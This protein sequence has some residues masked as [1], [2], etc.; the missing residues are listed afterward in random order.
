[1]PLKTFS[2]SRLLKL[3]FC[4][5]AF[6]F[7]Y[8]LNDEEFDTPLY[9][10]L[11][12]INNSQNIH[13]ARYQLKR[14]A[15]R[16]LFY[17]RN[18]K[19]HTR[20]QQLAEQGLFHSLE[21]H[22]IDTIINSCAPFGKSQFYLQTESCFVKWLETEDISSFELEEITVLGNIDFA[23]YDK[24]GINL[25][26]LSSKQDQQAKLNFM[27]CYGLRQLKAK[28]NK[29]NIGFLNSHEDNWFCEWQPINWHSY[30]EY[31]DEILNYQPPASLKETKA[32][33]SIHYCNTCEYSGICDKYSDILDT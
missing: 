6:Y 32:R 26:C 3:N 1:M 28:P 8:Q 9:T 15:L 19:P 30:Q 29:I 7:H 10:S 22:D 23:W 33:H 4:K 18:I 25:V 13:L 14:A 11:Q 31:I 20:K 16:Q 5:R 27:L 21:L 2:F 17:Q 12:E 24:A